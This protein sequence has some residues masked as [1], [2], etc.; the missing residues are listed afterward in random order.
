MLGL[1][2]RPETRLHADGSVAA[3]ASAVVEMSRFLMAIESFI[4]TLN[5]SWLVLV[6][7]NPVAKKNA[8]KRAFFWGVV[9]YLS[10][11]AEERLVATVSILI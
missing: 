1:F 10:T 7:T 2:E 6:N 5:Y 11:I 3:R 9:L 8:R 4:G